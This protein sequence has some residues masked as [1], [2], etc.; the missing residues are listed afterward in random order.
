M[1]LDITYK[2]MILFIISSANSSQVQIHISSYLFDIS[3][4]AA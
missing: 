1:A 2:L 3:P 4:G